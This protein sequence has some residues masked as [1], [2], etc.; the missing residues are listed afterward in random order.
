[1]AGASARNSARRSPPEFFRGAG[2]PTFNHIRKR[3]DQRIHGCVARHVSREPCSLASNHFLP[4]LRESKCDERDV[5]PLRSD[6]AHVIKVDA[7]GHVDQDEIAALGIVAKRMDAPYRAG[8]Y[9]T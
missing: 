3:L 5:R 2:D 7:F 1:M 4:L 8:K 6:A 9:S